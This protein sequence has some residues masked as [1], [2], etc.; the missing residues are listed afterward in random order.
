MNYLRCAT[1]VLIS[2]L[3]WAANAEAAIVKGGFSSVFFSRWTLSATG[4]WTSVAL[5]CADTLVRAFVNDGTAVEGEHWFRGNIGIAQS[6]YSMLSPAWATIQNEC[7]TVHVLDGVAYGFEE[8]GED[9]EIRLNFASAELVETMRAESTAHCVWLDED[10]GLEHAVRATTTCMPFTISG[11][12]ET[13]VVDA[14]RARTNNPL[15][16]PHDHA[17]SG[18]NALTLRLLAWLV[19]LMTVNARANGGW[20]NDA[21]WYVFVWTNAC[22][23]E[24][25]QDRVAAICESEDAD[26]PLVRN[27]RIRSRLVRELAVWVQE[28][29]PL[30]DHASLYGDL[31]RG[32]I[33]EVDWMRIVDSW[34][35]ELDTSHRQRPM[36]ET[37]LRV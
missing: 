5:P 29:N 28:K 37:A 30:R 17:I 36:T 25:W 33:D 18:P 31:L 20:T 10:V 13:E 4:P 21:T 26:S 9:V 3:V 16:A 19:V 24:Y 2:Q 8:F 1:L 22:A 11:W 12:K 14:T 7:H 32:V 15:F 6:V 27:Q 34:L 35:T 23:S